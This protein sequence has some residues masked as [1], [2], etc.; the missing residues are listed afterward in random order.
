[1]KKGTKKTGEGNVVQGNAGE[2]TVVSG[3]NSRPAIPSIH[4]TTF[5]S[6]LMGRLGLYES[7]LD[8]LTCG[9]WVSD[10]E[11]VIC[12]ANK[13]MEMIAGVTH[14]KLLGYNVLSDSSENTIDYFR[15]YYQEAKKV[16]QSVH[17]SEIPVVTPAG[18]QTYQSGWFIPRHNNGTYD[19]MV[20]I[21]EDITNQREIKEALI[22]SEAKYQEIVENVNS[23]IIRMDLRGNVTFLNRF[24]QD[25]F[26]FREAEILSRNAVGTIIPEKKT[27]VRS[28]REMIA[29]IGKDPGMYA[30]WEFENIRKDG[31]SAWISWT[32]KAVTDA[33]GEISEVLC[34]GN[35]ITELKYNERLLKKCRNDLEKKVELRTAQLVEANKRLQHE[36]HEYK[37]IEERLRNSEYKYRL[38]VE[39]ANEAIMVVQDGMCRYI[40]PKTEKITGYSKEELTANPFIKLLVHPHDQQMVLGRYLKLL[41][42]DSLPSVYSF[43]IVDKFGNIKWLEVNSVLID[44]MGRP[45]SLAFCSNITERKRSEERLRLLESAFHQAKDSIIITTTGTNYPS[46]EIVFVNPAF[47]K[48]TGYTAEEVMENPSIILQG[49]KTDGAE[50]L[51]LETDKTGGKAFY[52]ETVNYQKGGA[53][54]NLEW[55]ITPI[56]DDEG[57]ITHFALIHRDITERKKA[58]E[59]LL[60]YQKQLSSLASELLLAEEKERRR[61]ATMLHDHIGQSLAMAKI[62]M[63]VLSDSLD[64]DRYDSLLSDIRSLIEK[65]I[66][67]TKSL[68]FELSPPILY[69][70]GFELA[71][72]WLGEQIQKHHKINFEFHFDEKPKPLNRDVSV[73]MFQA[74]R[75]LSMNIVKH[76]HAQRVEVLIKREG[77]RMLVSI[78]DDGVG[79]DISE[80]DRTKSFGF[81]SIHERLK[82]FGGTFFVDTKPGLGTLVVLTAPVEVEEETDED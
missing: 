42:G 71:I 58:E 2:T 47:T 75:E 26:G 56:R 76:A 53:R 33:D 80:I 29:N 3:Q 66:Q 14:Q 28:F 35:D 72:E 8:G 5:D 24:A 67:Y 39:N 20:C 70:L 46:S 78:K 64:S 22:K 69:E 73:L 9:V 13:A 59:K 44:W 61:I 10:R 60:A 79:F 82:H 36:I 48:L 37:W 19:G 52:V 32:N 27:A 54:I 25:F 4:D 21:L 11:D 68:T 31:G 1:M 57:R 77:K 6:G 65:S 81:F 55:Q 45:A 62:Q 12:Y 23:I 63:G 38:V 18:R 41:K 49:P 17:Y 74:V 51:K 43:R 7:I 50:W 30:N 40:N 15:Q 16:L 34:V